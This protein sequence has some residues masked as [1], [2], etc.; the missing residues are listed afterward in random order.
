MNS[1]Y[2]TTTCLGKNFSNSLGRIH[3]KRNQTL[4]IRNSYPV[5]QNTVHHRSTY[6]KRRTC[7][8]YNTYS[9]SDYV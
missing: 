5:T 6:G 2:G 7:L 3:T 1:P 4:A 8:Y 9:I